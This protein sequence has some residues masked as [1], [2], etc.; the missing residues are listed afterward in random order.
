M[1]ALR[2]FLQFLHYRERQTLRNTNIYHTTYTVCDSNDKGGVAS[3]ISRAYAR[4][5]N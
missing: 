3:K 1:F 4:I 2:A 5:N